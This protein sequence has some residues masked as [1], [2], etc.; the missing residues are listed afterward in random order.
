[1]TPEI[2]FIEQGGPRLECLLEHGEGGRAVVITHP[3]PLYGGTMYNDVVETIS[4]VYK[5]CGFT[6]MRFNF[7]G[8]GRSEGSYEHGA[9]E[10]ADVLRAV[11]FVADLGKFDL[12]LAGYSFGAW[13]NRAALPESADVTCMV[14]VSPPVAFLDFED[15]EP[16]ERIK[17]VV[18][19]TQ[20]EMAP[21]PIL[22][23]AY[24]R[25]NPKARLELV[26]G[27]DHFYCARLPALS[28]IIDEFLQP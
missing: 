25:W 9:G 6:T 8:V 12:H 26:D 16:D 24:G 15:M 5:H 23:K 28:R 19:G 7:R 2:V 10:K 4:Q 27:A 21:E 13:I 11:E 14:M 17:L 1:M 20:D 3:H 18:A 22:R